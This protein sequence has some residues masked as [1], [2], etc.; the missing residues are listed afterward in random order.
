MGSDGRAVD[1]MYYVATPEFIQ[2]WTDAKKGELI[3]R[4]ERALGG[5]LP[6]FPSMENMIQKM[7]EANVGKVFITQT[8]MFSYRNKWMYMDT[9]LD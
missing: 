6:S 9:Q 8:K 7:D 4:M 5:S 3:C 2:K 1:I